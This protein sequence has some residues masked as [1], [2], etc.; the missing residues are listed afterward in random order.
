MKLSLAG[1]VVLVVIA[2]LAMW[3]TNTGVLVFSAASKIPKTRECSYF[4]GVS[5]LKRIEP[6]ADRCPLVRGIGT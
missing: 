5:V 3:A 6:L 1:A 4:I 2:W